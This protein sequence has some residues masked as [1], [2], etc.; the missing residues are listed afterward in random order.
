MAQGRDT[1]MLRDLMDRAAERLGQELKDQPV[2]EA[3][4]RATIGE[5]YAELGEYAKAEAMHRDALKLATKSYGMVHPEV[6]P[7]PLPHAG[8]H[9]GM[10][11]GQHRELVG[12]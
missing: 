10:V 2:A 6:A 11:F 7:G 3:E 1:K 9:P 8:L 12:E 5:V 4:M